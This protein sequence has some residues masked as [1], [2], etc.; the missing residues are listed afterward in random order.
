MTRTINK[1]TKLRIPNRL[2]RDKT[3]SLK[4]KGLLAVMLDL[5][6]DFYMTVDTLSQH[7]GQGR[8]AV[9]SAVR[10][11]EQKGYLERNKVRDKQRFSRIKYTIKL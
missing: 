3:L 2:L 7:I 10:E 9:G 6:E 5:P 11:L 1:S 8:D 4:A